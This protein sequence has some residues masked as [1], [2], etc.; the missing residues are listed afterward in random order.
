MNSEGLIR[1][2][3]HFTKES[4]DLTPLESFVIEA[5]RLYG[6]EGALNGF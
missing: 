4:A 5:I 2:L 1:Q 6:Q 3:E